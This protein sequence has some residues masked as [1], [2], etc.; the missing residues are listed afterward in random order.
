M[1]SKKK[2]TWLKTRHRV[3]TAVLRPLLYPVVCLRYHIRVER[4]KQQGDRNYLILMNHQ[5]PFDQ[6][7]V[8]MAFRKPVYYLATEDIFSLGWISRVLSWLVAPIPI[9]KQTTDLKAVMNCLKVG[10]EGGTIA[11]APEGNR[12]YSGR[13]EYIK[14]SIVPLA[15]K[16]KMPIA[17]LRIEGGY[18]IQPRWSD[19]IRRGKM[20]A[21]VSE[22]I[23]PENYLKMSDDELFSAIRDGLYVDEA[24]V[25]GEYRHR[26]LAEYLERA[27]YVCPFCGLAEFE[28][29]D[30]LVECKSCGRK[31]RYLPTKE[32]KGEGFDFPFP[33]VG[34]WYDYQKDF[35][36]R[37][38]LTAMTEAPLFRDTGK[39]S[40]VI[41]YQHKELLYKQ[42][43]LSLYGDRVLIQAPDGTE[44]NL[45]FAEMTASAVLGRNKLNI[46]FGDHVYQIYGGKRFNAMKYVNFFHRYQNIIK[47]E[48]NGEF[49]GL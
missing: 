16:L 7:F 4:F 40:E 12:T 11:L 27:V 41:L 29:H 48:T 20:R 8:A 32:L 15:K 38:D 10:R 44:I 37:L 2:K 23:E 46:Y 45:P 26:K 31:I 28:S 36:N 6:F 17:L 21:Y 22:V 39:L 42:V 14:S 43:Q 13:T 35:V 5:T 34:Q 25:D 19:V 30:D 9:K 49:L 47:G 3:I 18:G 24:K 33:F 1:Q